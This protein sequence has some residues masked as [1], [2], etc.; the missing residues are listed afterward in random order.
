[1]K[2]IVF[3]PG[4]LGSKE[5]WQ[6]VQDCL[7]DYPT[8]ALDLPSTNVLES[9]EQTIAE[10]CRTPPVLIGYSMGGR[11]AL[12]LQEQGAYEKVIVLGAHPGIASEQERQDILK[13]DEAWAH[14][15][16]TLSF[17]AF[18]EMWYSNPLFASLRSRTEQFEKM[19]Y[20]RKK[21]DPKACA[22]LL[23]NW[24]AGHF[25]PL[26]EF[27]SSMC[28]LYG[29][30]DHKYAQLYQSLSSDVAVQ[31]IKGCGHAAHIE[32]PAACAG[33]I[34]ELLKG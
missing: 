18:L 7:C 17:N 16:E 14:L 25:L 33:T 32:D 12:Q 21:N 27:S 13:R 1:M 10:H 34:R 2:E 30:L 22:S 23:R 26:S 19:I 9:L 15:L 8:V 4:F 6:E 3:L 11:M 5:D 29:E 20:R 24:S 28:F 31:M